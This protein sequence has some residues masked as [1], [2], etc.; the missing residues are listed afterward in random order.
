MLQ[1]G[2]SENKAWDKGRSLSSLSGGVIPGSRTE[3]RD[4]EMMTEREPMQECIMELAHA[5]GT[6][7]FDS[8]GT[9]DKPNEMHI[10]TIFLEQ[11]KELYS[12][13]SMSL[14]SKGRVVTP[15]Y[16]SNVLH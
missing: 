3:G 6:W 7:V 12:S 1:A 10:R 8:R 15:L 4:S 14:W 16:F 9:A 11:D 5:I 13:T 2:S